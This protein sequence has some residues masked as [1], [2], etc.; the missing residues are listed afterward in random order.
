MRVSDSKVR[1]PDERATCTCS[2]SLRLLIDAGK[3]V[4]LTNSLDNGAL[5]HARRL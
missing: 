5:I 3:V 4:E 2:A 1:C